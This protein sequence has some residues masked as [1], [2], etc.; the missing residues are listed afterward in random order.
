MA[1][2]PI[3]LQASDR[4]S[5][6]SLKFQTQ[7]STLTYEVRSTQVMDADGNVSCETNT[8]D[9]ALVTQEVKYCGTN[10]VSDL[11]TFLTKFGDLQGGACLTELVINMT[12]SDYCTISATAHNHDVNPHATGLPLGYGDMSVFMPSG[13]GDMFEN[14]DGFGVPFTALDL[15]SPQTATPESATYSFTSN[16]IDEYD[17]NGDHF[18]GK[19]ITLRHD[20]SIDFVGIPSSSSRI[21]VASDLSALGYIVDSVGSDD[22]SSEFDRFRVT[23]HGNVDLAVV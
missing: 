3:T 11:G 6:G 13:I 10:L 8:D 7:N 5:F 18:T 23:A 9:I 21:S 22:A 19:N 17:E 15:G 16:H 14:W 1:D 12:A 4:L 20:L 2:F